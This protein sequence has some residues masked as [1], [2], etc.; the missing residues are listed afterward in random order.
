MFR[1]LNKNL[2]Q[3]TLLSPL[4]LIFYMMH[5]LSAIKSRLTEGKVKWSHRSLLLNMFNVSGRLP[6][7][8]N[9]SHKQKNNIASS[10]L[11]RSHQRKS[12]PRHGDIRC[13]LL[14]MRFR[15]SQDRFFRFRAVTLVKFSPFWSNCTHRLP[16]HKPNCSDNVIKVQVGVYSRKKKNQFTLVCDEAENIT[17]VSSLWAQIIETTLA[18]HVRAKKSVQKVSYKMSNTQRIIVLT[19]GSACD[20]SVLQG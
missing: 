4:K 16:K 14:L 2:A 15:L 11:Q 19:R 5:R 8:V 10:V 1:T 13:R 3:T 9:P 6:R 18:R 20:Y 17:I 7:L 12:T